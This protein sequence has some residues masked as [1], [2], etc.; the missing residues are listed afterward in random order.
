MHVH[1]FPATVQPL[2]DPGFAAARGDR[3]TVL[4]SLGEA[5]VAEGHGI[6]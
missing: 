3:I 4:K 6:V 1:L 2:P 5:R